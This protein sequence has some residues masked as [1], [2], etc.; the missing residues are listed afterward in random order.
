VLG[1]AIPSLDRTA[2]MTGQFELVHHVRIPGMLHGRVV[3][4][5]E[6]RATVA[7]VDKQ[8]VR[9]VPVSC[10]SSVR[11][12]FVGV[13]A[14]TQDGGIGRNVI[15]G[16]RSSLQEAGQYVCA[17]DRSYKREEH[18]TTTMCLL[19]LAEYGRTRKVNA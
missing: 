18:F 6:M 7:R 10:K 19:T 14:E 9:S 5:P 8:S 17:P 4:P 12:N 15:C 3:R 11:K 13:V 2:L 1:K 16:F